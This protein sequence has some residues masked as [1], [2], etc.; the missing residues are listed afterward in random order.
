[1]G[2]GAHQGGKE[3]KPRERIVT[4]E[5]L[6]TGIPHRQ[7][8]IHLDNCISRLLNFRERFVTKCPLPPEG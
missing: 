6:F 2:A 1:M 8:E 7:E 5:R 4:E 3:G